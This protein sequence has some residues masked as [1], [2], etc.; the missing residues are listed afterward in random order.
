MVL[1]KSSSMAHYFIHLPILI[2]EQ[3][4]L[5][6]ELDEDFLQFNRRII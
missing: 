1:C 6:T 5:Y 3:I 2:I 4:T